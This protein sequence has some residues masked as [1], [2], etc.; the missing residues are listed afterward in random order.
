MTEARQT[1]LRILTFVVAI[2][3]SL[4]P[5]PTWLVWLCPDFVVMLLIYWVMATPERVGL[6]TAWC[7]GLLVDLFQ[8]N[9]LG[10]HALTF[11][12]VAY[13][14]LVL[15]KRLRVF[16]MVQQAMFVLCLVGLQHLLVMWVEGITGHT[17]Q[18]IGYFLSI[19]TSMLAWP[20]LTSVMYQLRRKR[21]FR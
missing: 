5:L 7:L 17:P 3:F 14:V 9:L 8:G 6:K 13:L 12:L 11:S 4:M 1:G 15:Y 20:W 10:L 18:D 21:I 19:I 2:L 16:P